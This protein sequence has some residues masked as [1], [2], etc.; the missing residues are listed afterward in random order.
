MKIYYLVPDNDK[1][2]MGIGIIYHHVRALMD[3][4]LEA[5]VVHENPGF[6]ITWLNLTVNVI[7]ISNLDVSKDDI[8]VF[9][10][11]FAFKARLYNFD[12]EKILFVQNISLLFYNFKINEDYVKLGFTRV[13]YYLN[14]MEGPLN[15]YVTLPMTHV[16]PVISE[17]FFN[18]NDKRSKTIVIYPKNEIREYNLLKSLIE[19]KINNINRSKILNR[20]GVKNWQL[21]ELRGFSH[22]ETASL[23]KKASIFISLN[24]FEA[25]NTSVPEAMAAGAVNVCYEAFGPRDFLI[26]N[27]NSIVVKNNEVFELFN[28]VEN[29]ID[30]IESGNTLRINEI[31]NNAYELSLDFTHDL[32]KNDLAKFYL[33][34]D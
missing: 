10:E 8:I 17:Y 3:L 11:V 29:L 15:R 16:R 27:V 5:Y 30:D 1:P 32:L 12:C 33:K 19:R 6:K 21:I 23:L 22:V 20:I 9:P 25:F 24:S 14:H 31:R 13:I 34:N 28:K 18:N 4:G 26:N 2:S 7:Y